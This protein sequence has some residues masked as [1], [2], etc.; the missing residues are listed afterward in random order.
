MSPRSMIPLT[1][2]RRLASLGTQLDAWFGEAPP[3]TLQ[4]EPP[5]RALRPQVR[6][7]LALWAKG[8]SRIVLVES[9][10]RT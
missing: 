5:L 8:H 3:L 4:P 1:L 9:S 10:S 2:S 6:N 7:R